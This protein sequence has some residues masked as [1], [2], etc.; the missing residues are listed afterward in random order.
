MKKMI[1]N[2]PTHT[3]VSPDLSRLYIV[4]GRVMFDD[5]D[6]VLVVEADSIGEAEAAFKEWIAE[7]EDKV[8]QTLVITSASLQSQLNDRLIAPALIHKV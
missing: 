8:D 2:V 1:Q 4:S 6:Q 3:A 7:S 5:D